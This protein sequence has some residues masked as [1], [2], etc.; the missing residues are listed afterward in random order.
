MEVIDITG[1][2]ADGMWNYSEPF[3]RFKLK[4]ITGIPWLSHKIYSD[5]FEGMHSQTGTYLE[6]PAHYF[7]CRE[8][9][10]IAD[11]PVEKLLDIPCSIIN[12]SRVAQAGQVQGD[13]K[14]NEDMKIIDEE[15]LTE[16]SKDCDILPGEAILVSTGWSRHWME[17]CFTGES[18]YFTYEAMRWLIS[19]KPFL[20]GSDF[21]CW[22]SSR[23]PQGFF[24]EFFSANILMLAPC[25]NLWQIREKKVLL[26]VLPLNIPNTSASPCRAVVKVK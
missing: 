4:S 12:I 22:D 3:P 14:D 24:K 23:N 25:D 2:I 18:P 9:Y 15:T 8:S 20:L 7:G 26:T 1:K 11:I 6:T 5:I 10:C 16:A 19:K 13:I 21:P 17:D